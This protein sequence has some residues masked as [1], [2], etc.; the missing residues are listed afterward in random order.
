MNYSEFE[1]RVQKAGLSTKRCSEEHWQIL[2]GLRIVNF[3]P[4]TSGGSK[5]Y[6]QGTAGGYKGDIAQ[7]ITA[8]TGNQSFNLT[9]KRHDRNDRDTNRNQRLQLLRSDPHCK[10]CGKRL[11][12]STSTLDHVVALS[13]GGSNGMDNTVLACA[14]CNSKRRNGT[15][16]KDLQ[17]Q[18]LSHPKDEE[19]VVVG[20]LAPAIISHDVRRQYKPPEPGNTEEAPF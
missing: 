1:S 13:N 2:G 15:K 7:A 19:P 9:N 6:I 14:E 16:I 11:Y 10:W 8:A 20:V 18:K 4:Y 12:L 3:Y 5:I 17:K